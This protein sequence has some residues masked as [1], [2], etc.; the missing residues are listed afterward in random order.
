MTPVTVRRHIGTSVGFKI[1]Q[2]VR[3]C[4]GNTIVL[5]K[6]KFL[7]LSLIYGSIIDKTEP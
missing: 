4:L 7:L 5:A 6:A 3:F 2:A 1:L